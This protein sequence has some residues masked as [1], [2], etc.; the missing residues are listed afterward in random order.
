MSSRSDLMGGST[1]DGD[2]IRTFIFWG[3]PRK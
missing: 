2:A 3:Q 1:S